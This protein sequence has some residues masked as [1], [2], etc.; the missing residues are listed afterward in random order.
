[1]AAYSLAV[2]RSAAKEIE[3][4]E[5]LAARRRIVARIRALAAEP[6]PAGSQQLSGEN[7]LYR[8]RQGP[9]RILY[10]VDD[11][12]R[13]IEIIKVGHRREVYR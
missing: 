3:G 12:A 13:S 7:G 10:R 6:R 8:I 9:Y 4:A 2:K 5:P 11:R 1:M